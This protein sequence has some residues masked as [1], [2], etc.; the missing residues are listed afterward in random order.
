MNHFDVIGVA[1]G[2]TSEQI[3]SAYWQ[4]LLRFRSGSF[5][6]WRMTLSGRSESKLAEAL[7]VLID[8]AKR[9]AYEQWLESRETRWV[10]PGH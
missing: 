9:D 3:H 5:E 2:A 8:A 1:R 4:A 10:S 7:D 6:R